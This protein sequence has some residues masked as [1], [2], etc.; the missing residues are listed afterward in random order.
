[1]W[2]HFGKLKGSGCCCCCECECE[3]ER[4]EIAPNE[5]SVAEKMLIVDG[6][7]VS[8]E[9]EEDSSE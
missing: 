6:C 7:N 5:P 3:S 9:E 4:E 1:L 2:G 8:E